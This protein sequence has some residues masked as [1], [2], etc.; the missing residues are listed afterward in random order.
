LARKTT[1]NGRRTAPPRAT[2]TRRT[3]SEPAAP[4]GYGFPPGYVP[5]WSQ[6]GINGLGSSI[7]LPIVTKFTEGV[8]EGLQNLLKFCALQAQMSDALFVQNQHLISE[9]SAMLNLGNPFP[10]IDLPGAAA[11]GTRK[12]TATTAG[13][14]VPAG[15]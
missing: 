12:R 6:G 15:A 10:G 7:V 4:P 13:E 1:I 14:A 9:R 11:T 3:T 8:M 5:Q 2:R